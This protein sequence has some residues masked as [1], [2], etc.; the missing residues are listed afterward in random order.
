[1]HDETKP[2]TTLSTPHWVICTMLLLLIASQTAGGNCVC[3]DVIGWLPQCSGNGSSIAFRAPLLFVYSSGSSSK[4]C[5]REN[6]QS[7]L[8]EWSDSELSCETAPLR[9]RNVCAWRFVHLYCHAN[10]AGCPPKTCKHPSRKRLHCIAD[11]GT[12]WT[13]FTFLKEPKI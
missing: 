7:D 6:H 10:A 9:C 2:H 8:T 1:M 5:F 12:W 4:T 13:P 11:I 3:L